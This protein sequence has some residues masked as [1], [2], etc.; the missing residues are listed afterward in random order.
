M[1]NSA[2]LRAN[3]N[4]HQ[5]KNK[6]SKADDKLIYQAMRDC[7]SYLEDRLSSHLAG[8]Y[9]VF[10]KQ[11][12]FGEL[13]SLIENKGLRAEFDKVFLTRRIKPDGGAIFLKKKEDPDYLRLVLVSEVKRQGTN[14]L[15]ALEGKKR[16]AVG[17]AIERLGKNLTG[18]RT[19]LNHEKITPF[20]CF[21]WGCDFTYEY[22]NSSFAMSKV[23]MLN[24]FYALNKVHI[25][26][27]DGSSD[28]NHFAPVSMFFK[29]QPWKK[30][31][32]LDVLKEVGETAL[33]YY[34]F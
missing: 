8:Y 4:Q 21:G 30:K 32:M 9:L 23:S 33:R 25:F 1:A 14:D 12:T 18:I 20:V 34:I 28:C 29:T 13:I 27:R 7:I 31:E 15:R 10:K 17:N 11:I 24:E 5:P 16:Q 19:A 3:R 2:Q 22:D 6:L 26:K